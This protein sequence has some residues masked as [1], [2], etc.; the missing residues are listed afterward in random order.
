MPDGVRGRPR[1]LLTTDAVGGVWR[2]SVDLARGL[3]ER[4]VEVVLA[5]LGPAASGAQRGEAEAIAGLRLVQTGLA[6]DWTAESAA[7]LA[8]ATDGWPGWRGCWRSRACICMRRRWWDERGGRHRWWRWRIPAWGR[9]A[10]DA[11]GR[12]AG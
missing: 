8:A 7:E 2:Y 12:A 6:L 10:G 5:V 9:V 1:L 3:S 11:R 4:G